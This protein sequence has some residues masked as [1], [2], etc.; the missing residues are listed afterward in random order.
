VASGNSPQVGSIPVS[1]VVVVVPVVVV[2]VVDVVVVVS[3][4]V[5][6]VVVVPDVVVPVVEDVDEPTPVS[7]VVLVSSIDSSAQPDMRTSGAIRKRT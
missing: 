5:V 2:P 1:V 6:S 3:V 4:V 7:T